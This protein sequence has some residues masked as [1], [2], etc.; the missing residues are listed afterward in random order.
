MTV[1][2]YLEAIPDPVIRSKALE[3]L[4]K[5]Y[6]QEWTISADA[7][8]FRAFIWHRTME[9]YKYWNDVHDQLKLQQ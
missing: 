7:A 2:Q 6:G 1:K 3:N 4:W 5:E 8:L 9:G